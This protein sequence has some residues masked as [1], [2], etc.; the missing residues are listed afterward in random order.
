MIWRKI[1]TT[2][3]LKGYRQLNDSLEGVRVFFLLYF[4]NFLIG[5]VN[6][7]ILRRTNKRYK[8]I[9]LTKEALS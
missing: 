1:N 6:N 7:F 3:N 5:F 8:T 4:F 2:F 9:T